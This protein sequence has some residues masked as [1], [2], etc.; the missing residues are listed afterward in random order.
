MVESVSLPTL[1]CIVKSRWRLVGFGVAALC[2]FTGGS[3]LFLET[4]LST[5]VVGGAFVIAGMLVLVS[6]VRSKILVTQDFVE[7]RGFSGHVRRISWSRVTGVRTVSG[8]SVLPSRTI[9]LIIEDEEEFPLNN[10][11][12]YSIFFPRREPKNVRLLKMLVDHFSNGE[13]R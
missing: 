11:S 1:P 8:P 12:W 6:S 9:A 2:L 4:L 13:D 10:L 7:E 3:I 5:L